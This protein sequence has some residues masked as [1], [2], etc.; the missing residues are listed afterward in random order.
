M[1]WTNSV[2]ISPYTDDVP[3]KGP[4]TR[5]ILPNGEYETIPENPGIRFV[6][7]HFRGLNRVV[8][9]MRYSGGRLSCTKSI[10]CAPEVTILGHRCTHEGRLWD[11]SRVA[12][13]TNW[14]ACTDLTDI[15]SFLGTIGVC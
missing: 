5:Y 9:H 10:I 12:V 14:G 1:G 11:E 8:A 13:V 6:Q 3:I 15:R 2:P 7:E 4:Q